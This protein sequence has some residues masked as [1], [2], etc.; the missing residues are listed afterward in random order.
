MCYNLGLIFIA[1]ICPVNNILIKVIADTIAG[2]VVKLE[3]QILLYK[4]P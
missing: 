3:K 1:M 4:G 2:I